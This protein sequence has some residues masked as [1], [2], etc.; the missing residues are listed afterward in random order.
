[1]ST[2]FYL[3]SELGLR[4]TL[5][6]YIRAIL[7]IFFKSLKVDGKDSTSKSLIPMVTDTDLDVLLGNLELPI[8]V[9]NS[10]PRHRM[11]YQHYVSFLHQL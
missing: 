11:R 5:S 1:M 4:K 10:Y 3:W 6:R 2:F 8:H 9:D 7:G